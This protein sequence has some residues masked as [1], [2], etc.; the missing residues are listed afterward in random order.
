MIS[1]DD[2]IDLGYLPKDLW[3][4]RLPTSL[5]DRAP[6]VE[7]RGEKG[8]FW[9]CDGE[10]WGDY[11]GERWF[12][13]PKRNPLALDRGGVGEPNRPT[14]PDKR[15]TDMDRD[16]VEASLMFPPIIAMQVGEP[17]LRNACVRAYNDWA[18]EFG[19]AGPGR[20]FPVAML[21]PVEPEAAKDEVIRV[22]KLGFREANFLVND[23][24]VDMYLKPWDVFWDAAEE[25]G[26]VVSYHVGGSVQAGTVRAT[27]DALK[28]D[29]RQMTFDMGLGNG[30]TSFFNPFVNLFN[31]GTLE[32]H[33]K[34]KFCLAES[35]IGWIPFVVQE[36]DYRYKRQ[37]E[38]KKATEIPLKAMPSEI[39]KRQVWATYQTDLVG[40]HLIEFFGDGH[41]MWGSDYPHPDS[42][43]P[44]SNE[45]IEKDTGHLSPEM[46][47][48]VIH[49]NAAALYGL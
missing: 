6:H 12:S 26:I 33:P 42:T 9:V 16:G 8:E 18:V 47:K 43:W 23:V 44:F 20:F 36:M 41:I 30:A 24:T 25:A 22:A 37:F 45:T 48:K 2:H 40:L 49:D 5:K 38:R 10:T 1:A 39:F 46:K 11:R 27:M 13:R 14:T 19:Q 31:F 29:Q 15:L 34:L 35:A 4:D 21:S 32:R 28:P 3:T 7:D 17:V